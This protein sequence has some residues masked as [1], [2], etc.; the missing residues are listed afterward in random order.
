[1]D[2]LARTHVDEFNDMQRARNVMALVSGNTHHARI[3][4]LSGNLNLLAQQ[5]R[6]LSTAEDAAKL[7]GQMKDVMFDLVSNGMNLQ[8]SLNLQTH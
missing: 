3:G 2:R 1:M 4:R 5:V 7:R 8:V 6:D